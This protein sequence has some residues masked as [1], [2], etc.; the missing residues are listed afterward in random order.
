MIALILISIFFQK[1]VTKDFFPLID[2]LPVSLA[3]QA[4]GTTEREE[5]TSHNSDEPIIEKDLKA[6]AS[7]DKARTTLD[8][9]D[10]CFD[11][12]AQWKPVGVLWIADDDELK[13]GEN[14]VREL[15]TAG[16]KASSYGARFS[17][18]EGNLIITRSVEKMG[19]DC[20]R[21]RQ[22]NSIFLSFSFKGAHLMHPSQLRFHPRTNLEAMLFLS[23]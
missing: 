9:Q 4:S 3:G 18:T 10:H 22:L 11:H 21:Y 20:S 8:A 12:P 13:I 15:Q 23:T 5:E 7:P 2:N 1:L 17:S 14:G 6:H 19:W 16:L